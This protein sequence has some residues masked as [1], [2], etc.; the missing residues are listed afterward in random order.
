M[1]NDCFSAE[2]EAS[3]PQKELEFLLGQHIDIKTG[4]GSFD[5][6][7]KQGKN[8]SGYTT[9]FL[10]DPK[11]S[12]AA[13]SSAGRELK[14]HQ[15]LL[16]NYLSVKDQLEK[17]LSDKAKKS[18]R[19]LQD[20]ILQASA[21][22]IMEDTLSKD[23]EGHPCSVPTFEN[24]N[25]NELNHQVMKLVTY[26]MKEDFQDDLTKQV[27]LNTARSMLGFKFK[28]EPDF[29]KKGAASLAELDSVIHNVC[30]KKI[31]LNG[32]KD[33]SYDICNDLGPNFKGKLQSDLSFFALSL[34]KN[35]KKFDPESATNS[36][37]ASIDR[38]NTKLERIPIVAEQGLFS[39]SVNLVNKETK[40]QYDRYV[41]L[42][43][44]EVSKDSGPLLLTSAM[45]KKAGP[46]KSFNTDDVDKDK[47]S[48]DFKF[49]KHN[50]VSSD[51]VKK[52]IDEAREKIQSQADSAIDL[53]YKKNVKKDERVLFSRGNKSDGQRTRDINELVK[54][55]PFAAGAVL[56]RRPEYAGT[57]C[58]SL[59]KIAA[60]DYRDKKFEEAF[61]AGGAVLG[62][63]LVI[64]S[65]GS[66]AGVV[67][68]SVVLYT[69]LA[70]AFFET[71]SFAYYGS[72]SYKSYDEMNRSESAYL[73]KNADGQSLI[74]AKEALVEF[75]EARLTSVLSLL[76][77]GLT[78]FPLK[79]ILD[80][81]ER[82]DGAASPEEVRNASRVLSA[83]KNHGVAKRLQD[84]ISL[85]GSLG[86]EKMSHFLV[87]LVKGG[88]NLLTKFLGCLRDSTIPTAKIESVVENALSSLD[89]Q[90]HVALARD[91]TNLVKAR[92]KEKILERSKEEALEYSNEEVL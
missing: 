10:S 87:L 25:I 75:K 49:T 46:I 26:K 91:L 27:L 38:I 68:E 30:S 54:I 41:D 4:V 90:F 85:M 2:K 23:T 59:N 24:K 65:L 83:I 71:A 16:A 29:M 47:K 89:S 20:R 84:I 28:F 44:E 35:E 53:T 11:N 69:T 58:E 6:I 55:N 67:A 78:V 21:Q 33:S 82:T 70:G 3:N 45:K 12:A 74:E 52:S 37:N 76:S 51:D 62:G 63:V 19:K 34:N 9:K 13:N 66:M 79:K 8:L 86:E 7:N 18:G 73:T 48:H 72:K 32:S 57:I 50:H 92:S 60:K 61:I 15:A 81:L 77:S 14:T 88:E 64:T 40:K 42:Y 5:L 39:D 17:C 1:R 22:A 56:V 31:S 43:A 80:L 36:L